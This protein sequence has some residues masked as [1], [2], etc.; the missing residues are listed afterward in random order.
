MKS[1]DEIE[2]IRST[3]EKALRFQEYVLRRAWGIYYALWAAIISS[4]LVVPSLV[5]LFYPSAPGYL[6]FLFYSIASLLGTLA[7]TRIFLVARRTL[8]LRNALHRRGRASSYRG[9]LLIWLAVFVAF[10][11]A[12]AASESAFIA[13]YVAVLTFIDAYIYRALR[14]SF[15]RIPFEGYVALGTYTVS[16]AVFA[17]SF[18]RVLPSISMTAST[19][20]TVAG[21]VFSALY[22]LYHAPEA[23]VE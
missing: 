1:E 3:Y 9:V 20:I 8:E 2:L 11:A 4:Y 15:P 23:M 21:W 6:Y 22:A 19:A 10:A 16:I 14:L 13:T 18:L 5:S 12:A 7:T 17:L